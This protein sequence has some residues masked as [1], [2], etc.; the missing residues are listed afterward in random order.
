[1]DFGFFC[2]KIGILSDLLIIHDDLNNSQV[3][4]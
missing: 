4:I 3:A 1:M 2:E